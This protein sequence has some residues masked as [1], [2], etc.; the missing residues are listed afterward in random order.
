MRK[1]SHDSF[2]IEL[3][4]ACNNDCMHCYNVWKNPIDYPEG[5]F[6]TSDTLSMLERLIEQAEPNLLTLTGGEPLLRSDIF[7]IID[8]ISEKG[9]GV[10]LITNG[11]LLS[12]D[13]I[14]KL[15]GKKS[16]KI[17]YK[18]YHIRDSETHETIKEDLRIVKKAQE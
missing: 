15:A 11:T 16:V 18:V 7:D 13:V 10:N 17:N 8:F 4:Q 14:K 3:T 1:V 2:V 12:E 5:Q 6:D 9:I